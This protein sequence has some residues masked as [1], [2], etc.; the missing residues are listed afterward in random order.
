MKPLKIKKVELITYG[1]PNQDK[2]WWA[3]ANKPAY[4]THNV[5][6]ITTEDGYVGLGSTYSF[7]DDDF[8]YA[9]F[10]SARTYAN[11]ILGESALDR[12]A[13]WYKMMG[14]PNS[15]ANAPVSMYDIALWDIV[16]KYA[17]LPLYQ[18]LGGY[19]DKILAYASG[20]TYNTIPEYLDNIQKAID[21]GYKAFKLHCYCIYER[22]LELVMAVQEKFGDSGIRF[23]LDPDLRYNREDSIKM[24][25]VLEAFGWDWLESPTSDYDYIGYKKIVDKTNVPLSCGGNLM[26]NLQE[27]ANYIRLDAWTDVRADTSVNGG[28]TPMRKIMNLAEANF[29]RCEVQSWGN[30]IQMAANL[31]I[32]LSHNNCTY[33]EHAYPHTTHDLG[34]VKTFDIDS[35][36]FIHAPEGYGLG[37]DLDW[38]V[39]EKY[40]LRYK[41]IENEEIIEKVG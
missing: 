17:K 4:F 12:E 23:S 35:E 2:P 22:D 14:K 40:K 19:R 1:D 26:L 13:L 41:C 21:H 3:L 8:E 33:F 15:M 5:C 31:H 38:D 11:A 34:S 32:M 30:T 36:G 7:C 18:L 29:M 6:R 20:M 28:I 9:T 37:V 10:E 16:G 39:V 25:R 27:I 24:A